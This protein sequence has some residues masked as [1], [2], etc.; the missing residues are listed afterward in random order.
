MVS[1]IG[2]GGGSGVSFLKNSDLYF[3]K[4]RVRAMVNPSF[5]PQRSHA[6]SVRPDLNQLY[7]A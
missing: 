3:P 7:A 6:G 5:P 2:G 1:V 4:S